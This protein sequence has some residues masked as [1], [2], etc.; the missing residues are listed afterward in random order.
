MGAQAGLGAKTRRNTNASDC[1]I[2]SRQ[3]ATI[4]DFN[5]KTS[6]NPPTEIGPSR[7]AQE[8]TTDGQDQ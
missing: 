5:K 7:I 3:K 1:S 8:F 2:T 6:F 4:S